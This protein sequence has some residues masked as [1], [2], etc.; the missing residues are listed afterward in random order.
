MQELFGLIGSLCFAFSSWPQ[1]YYSWRHKSAKGI[2]WS[3]IFLWLSGA[4]FSAIYAAY[5]HKYM[6]LPNFFCGA[7]GTLVIL[8]IR[9]RE[10]WR[11]KRG[12]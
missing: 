7:A 11:E 3:F 2:R 12:A 10:Y 8:Y 5:Y 4:F 9:V 6:L 1:A